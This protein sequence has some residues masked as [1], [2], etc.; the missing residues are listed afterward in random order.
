MWVGGVSCSYFL[1]EMT[2]SLFFFCAQHIRILI[3]PLSNNAVICDSIV[4]ACQDLEEVPNFLVSSNVV[5][6]RR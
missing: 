6:S 3:F 5:S 2:F 4:L 1:S